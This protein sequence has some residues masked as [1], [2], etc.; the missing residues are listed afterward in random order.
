MDTTHDI[1]AVL[2]AIHRLELEYEKLPSSKRT[3]QF[4]RALAV[5]VLGS[6][7]HVL[8]CS[9]TISIVVNDLIVALLETNEGARAELFKIAD[10]D[11]DARSRADR[12]RNT[13][14]AM[15][16]AVLE[17]AVECGEQEKIW[18]EKIVNVLGIS[19]F[20][21][22]RRGEKNS[23]SPTSLIYWRR[24]CAEGR[25]SC[26]DLYRHKLEEC[27]KIGRS[28]PELLGD[29]A[30][31]CAAMFGPTKSSSKSNVASFWQAVSQLSAARTALVPTP[32]AKRN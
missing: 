1:H 22:I 3:P 31:C 14:Q 23:F 6:F 24:N 8:Q 15:A 12:S 32:P 21:S 20:Q 5:E 9:S 10:D 2:S 30:N 11:Q 18:A 4:R 19:G 13:T 29:V 28:P 27:R 25:H 7:Q 17:Y 16:A 26:S